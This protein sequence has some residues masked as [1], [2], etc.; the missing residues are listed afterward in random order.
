MV[1]IRETDWTI[2]A[3]LL[4]FKHEHNHSTSFKNIKESNLFW[5]FD[6]FL[7][8]FNL[9]AKINRIIK[10]NQKLL[11]LNNW[12]LR[13]KKNSHF[14]FNQSQN[15]ADFK[16]NPISLFAFLI[17]KDYLIDNYIKQNFFLY[18]I[19]KIKKSKLIKNLA[20]IWLFDSFYV[21]EFFLLKI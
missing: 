20:N 1:H 7:D 4:E 19:K 14:P 16:F 17:L 9:C 8:S 2:E 11:F 5:I 3:P 15:V 21:Q 6:K 18:W 13:C 12:I 10:N